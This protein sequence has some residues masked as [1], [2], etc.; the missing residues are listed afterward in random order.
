MTLR[1]LSISALLA[2]APLH[3]AEEKEAGGWW[4]PAWT[5]RQ[6]ITIDASSDTKLPDATGPANVLI[7]LHDGNFQFTSV[8]QGGADIRFVG[9]DGTV[10]PHQVE[11]FDSSLLNEGLVW[12]KVP[13][14]SP[15]AQTTF[16]LYYGNAAP[17][18]AGKATDTYDENTAALYHFAEAGNPADATA[19]A[20]NASNAGTLS[21]GSLVGNGLRLLGTGDP[22]SIP[23]SPSLAWSDGGAATVSVW[24]NP[25]ALEANAVILSRND[26]GKSFRLVLDQGVPVVEVGGARSTP[27]APITAGAW[28]H[29]AVVSNAGAVKL[30]LNGAEYSL[31]QVAMP[32]L[33]SAI[34]IGGAASG[35][36]FKGEIDELRFDKVARSAGWVK[37]AAVSQGTTDAAQRL[38]ALGQAES[39]EGGGEKH[40]GGALEHV[41]LFGDIAKN[42]MFDGWI[43]IGVCVIMIIAGWTVAI[44]K[45]AY[46]NSIDKGTKEFM[47][48]WKSLSSDLTALDHSCNT[49]VKSLGGNADPATEALIRKSPL[50]EIYQIGSTEIRHRLEQD[51][52]HRKGLTGRSIQAIRAS[53]DGGLVHETHRLTNG[54]VFLTMSI[55]GGPYVG[56]LGTVVGVMIT[57]AII[58]KSGEVNVNSIAP[59]IASALLATVVGLIVAIPALFIYSYLNSRIKNATAIMQ[60]FIDE[61][62]AKMA[63]FYQGSEN[64]GSVS[65]TIE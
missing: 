19:N 56:L 13:D 41:M 28:T 64:S 21:E 54:L 20:N 24:I 16:N 4:N 22:V 14:I 44:K 25:S 30:Y 61:F 36:R 35:G 38:V 42:M 2:A 37:L 5:Q 32:A 40:S 53:L 50:F 1:L 27:G 57:F 51:R 63:E 7:R 65:K 43:A 26:G 59:G 29:L 18:A 11:K 52:A 45:F 12:V 60:V 55:A 8:A 9:D 23:P 49:S 62:V 39:G 31:A 3:A 46:L 17:D 47:R 48:M 15:G 34:E 33:N 10:Y 58:A 6:K